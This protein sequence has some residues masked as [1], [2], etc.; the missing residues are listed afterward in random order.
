A[1]YAERDGGCPQLATCGHSFLTSPFGGAPRRRRAHCAPM[2][3]GVVGPGIMGAPMARNL[4]KAGHDVVVVG[5]TPARVEARVAEG[6]GA[7]ASP[8]ALAGQVEVVVTSLPDGPDVELVV[9]GPAG[10]LEGASPGLVVVDTSTIAPATA[11]A[12]AGRCRE[13]GVAFLD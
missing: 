4:R 10:L 11:R 2:R 12:L 9:A 1:L 8:A 5:R 13:R 6:A 7:A 3:V